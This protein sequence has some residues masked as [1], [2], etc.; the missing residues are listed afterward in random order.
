ML[1]FLF[2]RAPTVMTQSAASAGFGQRGQLGN[3]LLDSR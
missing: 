3:P 1:F 2:V